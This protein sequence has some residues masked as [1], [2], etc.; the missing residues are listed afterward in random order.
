M[1]VK[2]VKVL[3]NKIIF[4]PKGNIIKIINKKNKYFFKFGELYFS[5]VKKNKTKGW[6][7]HYNY[8]CILSVPVGHIIFSYFYP[9]LKKK[10]KSIEINNKNNLT[11]IIPPGV[12]FS[13]KSMHKLSVV[14]NILSGIHSSKESAKKQI[15]NNVRI[16]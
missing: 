2:L 16:Q 9:N 8:F 7:I 5:Q 3:K 6:N 4:N 1:K 12:W 10:I 14:A 11:I 13:F 15:I